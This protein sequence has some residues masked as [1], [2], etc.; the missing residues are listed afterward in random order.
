MNRLKIVL[1]IAVAALAIA[2][3][4]ARAATESSFRVDISYVVSPNPDTACDGTRDT[5]SGLVAESSTT[6]AG[7]WTG[8]ECADLIAN[9]G[10]ITIHDG[11]FLIADRS[12]NTITGTYSGHAGAPDS[13]LNVYPSGTFTITGGRG[14]YE[15]ATGGGIFAGTANLSGPA[16]ATFSGTIDLP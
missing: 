14:L 11:T 13:G 7:T 5:A 10:S 6:G 9:P 12:N 16:T 2:P 1:S 3:F 4:A 8:T 15:G